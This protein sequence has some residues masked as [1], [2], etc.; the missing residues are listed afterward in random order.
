MALHEERLPTYFWIWCECHPQFKPFLLCICLA[1]QLMTHPIEFFLPYLSLI[2]LMTKSVLAV[3]NMLKSSLMIKHD[4]ACLDLRKPLMK[5]CH[6]K[7]LSSERCWAALEQTLYA[8]PTKIQTS[9]QCSL[10]KS[11][12]KKQLIMARRRVIWFDSFLCL[13]SPSLCFFI[14]IL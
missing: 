7:P 8:E 11:A 3:W 13:V 12:M 6:N 14:G 1:F 2:A 4:T 9:W 5:V 10:R